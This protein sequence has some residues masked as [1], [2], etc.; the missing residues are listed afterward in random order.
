MFFS[1]SAFARITVRFGINSITVNQRAGA[2]QIPVL[3]EGDPTPNGQYNSSMSYRAQDG[4]AVF[5]THYFYN[6]GFL[7]N[8][9]DYEPGDS[10]SKYLTFSINFTESVLDRTFTVLLDPTDTDYPVNTY[11]A[12][13]DDPSFVNVK[14]LGVSPQYLALKSKYNRFEKKLKKT[15]RIKDSKR[16]KSVARKLKKKL[17]KVTSQLNRTI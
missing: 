5:D 15:K 12:D 6:V 11:D 16:R 7:G 9:I 10:R 14:I 4:T 2:I 13:A 1:S 3:I 17:N 8:H